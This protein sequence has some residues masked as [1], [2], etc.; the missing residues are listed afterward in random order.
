MIEKVF[1]PRKQSRPRS[2]GP[3]EPTPRRSL[4]SL[5]GG[6]RTSFNLVPEPDLIDLL[7][8][9]AA[10]N[11]LMA[12][13]MIATLAMASA[14]SEEE[15]LSHHFLDTSNHV[16][17][18]S[19][20]KVGL[21]RSASAAHRRRSGFSPG[22]RQTG[23]VSLSRVERTDSVSLDALKAQREEAL[24]VL[25]SFFNVCKHCEFMFEISIHFYAMISLNASCFQPCA[26]LGRLIYP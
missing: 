13:E 8:V 19:N 22:A 25:T 14:T 11:P 23:I 20:K 15:K 21:K 9:R 24:R 12:A 26:M 16:A 2:P 17:L 5:I 4:S 18:K 7:H 6:R 1:S 3:S 10:G